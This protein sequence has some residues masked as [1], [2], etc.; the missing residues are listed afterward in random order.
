VLVPLVQVAIAAVLPLQHGALAAPAEAVPDPQSAEVQPR[1]RTVVRRPG[2]HALERRTPGFVTVVELDDER[3]TRPRDGLAEVL[4][5]APATHVRSIGGLGQFASVSLRGSS[6]QQVGIFLDGVPVTSSMAGLIDVADLPL[7]GMSRVEIH[8]GWI[9]IA[10]GA[11]AIGGALNLVST[12]AEQRPRARIDVGL[13]SFWTR[14]AAGEIATRVRR[15]TIGVRAG[16]AGTQGNY[17][18]YDDGGTAQLTG[19]DRIGRRSA[20]NYDRVLGQLRLDGRVG[21]W[22]LGAHQLVVAKRAGVPGPGSAQAQHSLLD[23]FLSRSIFH[24]RRGELGGPGGRLEWLASFGVEA[25]RFAD[26]RG[27]I[28]LGI[29]D[30]RTLAF[31]GYLSPRWRTPLWRGAFLMLLADHRSEW[32]GVDQRITRADGSPSGDAHRRRHAFGAGVELEQFA[33]NDRLHVVPAVRV[34]AVASAF[35]VPAGSGE[36]DDRGRNR[37]DAS[38]SPRMGVRLATTRWLSLRGSIGRYFR[39]PSLVELFGDRG[40]F[41]GNEGLHAERGLVADGGFV[42]DARGRA[43]EVYAHAAGFWVRSRELIQWIAA[44]TVARPENVAAA[45]V[46][47][48]EG[49]VSLRSTADVVELLVHYTLLDSAD[50]SDDASRRGHPLPGRPRHDFY[51]RS[52]FGWIFHPRGTAFEPRIGYTVEVI[53]RSFLDPSGRYV[54]P[55]RALQAIGIEAHVAGRVHLAVEVRNLLDVRTA[56]VTLPIAGV[57]PS[58]VAVTDYIGYPLPGRSLWATVRIDFALQPRRSST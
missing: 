41:V 14:Q 21:R 31:D 3:G 56:T 17:R 15:L 35:A 44:G 4:A 34:D 33:W 42:I 12:D 36:Q 37:F 50:R 22:K 29:D 28:G 26:P 20:N 10:F 8:R 7:D 47:G 11:G 58:P 53:A 55:P 18:Y 1:Y 27:E 54:L 57:R 49:S 23:Q 5:R 19:D 48:F 43:G 39:T 32:I 16:Y 51:A 24:A 45:R 40:Y 38:V 46:R 9:P 13:G 30:Q 52:S 2:R 6:P 25:R